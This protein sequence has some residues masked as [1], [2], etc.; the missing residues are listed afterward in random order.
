MNH[1]QFSIPEEHNI[2]HVPVEPGPEKGVDLGAESYEKTSENRAIVSDVSLTTSLP[3]PVINNQIVDENAT[4]SDMPIIAKDDDLIEKEWVNKAKRIVN[5]TRDDPHKRD[6]EV[7]K[8]QV[9]YLKKR[10][11]KELGVTE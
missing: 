1:E 4:T 3:T 8:L 2:E 10:Y 9:D 6:E 5:D 11:G 7:N